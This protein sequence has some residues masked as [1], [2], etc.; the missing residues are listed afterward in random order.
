MADPVR[1]AEA[2]ARA[3]KR[4]EEYR[5]AAQAERYVELLERLRT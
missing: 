5:W 1:A 2:V 3:S 4:Y